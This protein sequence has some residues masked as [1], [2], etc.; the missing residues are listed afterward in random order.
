M[1]RYETFHEMLVPMLVHGVGAQSYLEFGTFKNATMVNVHCPR[2]YGVDIRP[3]KMP[4][5]KWFAMMTSEFIAQH[6][7][8]CAPY[9]VVFIDADHSAD[10]A[11]ADMRGIWP[12]VTPEGLVLLHD[13]N[14][15]KE[16]DTSPGLCGDSWELAEMLKHRRYEAVTLPYHP[17]LTIV[18]K[19]EKWGPE[20]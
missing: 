13:T 6:A 18:R 19:R 16:A 15:E 1:R 3:I 14:P 9:D 10:A 12:H 7:A 4:G 2:R 17:G 5:V 11:W 8:E 20:K